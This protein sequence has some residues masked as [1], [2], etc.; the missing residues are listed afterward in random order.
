MTTL[1]IL[2]VP[3]DNNPDDNPQHIITDDT[4]TDTHV[5]Y[6]NIPDN[7][8]LDNITNDNPTDTV[9]PK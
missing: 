2:Y 7:Y 8:A 4:E 5:P 6:D 9:H 1:Q 3:N